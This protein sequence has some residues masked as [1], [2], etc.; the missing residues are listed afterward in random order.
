[1]G[2]Q[3]EQFAEASRTDGYARRQPELTVLHRTLRAHWPAFV[4]QAE[5]AGGLPG[6]VTREVQEYLRCEL[7]EH[8]LALLAC[9]VCGKS[10]VVAFS[11]KRRGFC[12]SCCG[13]R[14]SDASLQLT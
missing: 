1:M 5:Q 12:P 4:E 2:Q 9:E 3:A 7:L 11:C 6:L 13:R 14:M 10:L 8:G